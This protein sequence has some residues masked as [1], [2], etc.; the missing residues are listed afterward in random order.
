MEPKVYIVV[1]NWNGRDETLAC[2]WSLRRIAYDNYRIILVD[3]GST[4]GSP[5]EVA[6]LFPEVLL[7]RNVKNVGFDEGNNIG[8]RAAIEKKADAVLLLNN[9]TVVC[10][11]ILRILSGTAAIYPDAG[12]L[13][14]KIYYF[15]DPTSIWWAGSRRKYSETGWL[16]TYTQ[17][18]KMQKDVGQFDEVKKIDAVI[19]CAMY[20]KT[21]VIDEIGYLDARYFIYHE[22]YDF[23]RRAKEKG[24]RCYLVPDAKVWHKISLSMG[25]KDS[26]SLYHLW[27]RNWLLLSR[28]QTNLLLWPLLYYYY[29]KESFWV[30]QG[31]RARSVNDSAEASLAGAWSAIINRFGPPGNAAPPRWLSRIAGWDYKRKINTGG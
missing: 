24:W 29:L 8:I 21:E 18:G 25:G 28:K 5:E 11:N 26:P 16:L 10:R 27:T 23:C 15:D 3:N 2:L 13:G 14:P 4:D 22:E 12:I 20:I 17:E 31:L 30:Y 6:R 1:L 7:I 19:G 9:D